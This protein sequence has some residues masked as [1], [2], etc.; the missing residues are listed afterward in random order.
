MDSYVQLKSMSE[1]RVPIF[2]YALQIEI[3]E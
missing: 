2:L 3:V 1:N